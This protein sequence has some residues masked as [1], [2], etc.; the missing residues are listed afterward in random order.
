[1]RTGSIVA[2]FQS[3][4]RARVWLGLTTGLF[5]GAVAQAQPQRTATAEAIIIEGFVIRVTVTD[6]GAGYLLPPTVTISGGGGSGATAVATVANG[7]VV[8][9]EVMN[10][11]RNYVTRPLVEIGPPSPPEAAVLESVRLQSV[12]TIRGKVGTTN[13]I[14][15]ADVLAPNTWRVLTNLVVTR[16]PYVFIDTEAAMS[17]RY[18]RVATGPPAPPFPVDAGLFDWIAPGTLRSR[19][20][21]SDTRGGTDEAP[22]TQ[23]T[24]TQGFFLRRYEV[25]RREYLSVIGSKPSHSAGNP[26]GPAEIM[27]SQDIVNYCAR[28]TTCEREAGRLPAGWAYRLPTEAEHAYASLAVAAHP[29]NSHTP[30]Q[31]Q[32]DIGTRVVLA[33]EEP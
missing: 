6:G 12:V 22:Q 18:Y 7:A 21:E 31:R 19:S 32:N 26:N 10:A 4:T 16:S 30:D 25:T 17:Q 5:L 8:R 2:R 27:S 28:L 14:L 23:L 9:I 29:S 24:L 15:A 33:L 20:L 13:W 11:G 1:M 3:R